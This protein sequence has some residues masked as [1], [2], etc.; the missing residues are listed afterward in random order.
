MTEAELLR[1][2]REILCKEFEVAEESLRPEAR[3]HEDLDL[4]SLDAAVLAVRL[5]EETGL[6]VH[7]DLANSVR[8]VQDIVDGLRS[9]LQRRNA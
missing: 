7:D 8:T 6:V 5:E 9:Q 1:T 3:L 4:D 2:M